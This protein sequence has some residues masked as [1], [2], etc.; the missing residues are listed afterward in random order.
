MSY[1]FTLTY[2]A[3]WD[4]LESDSTFTDA[5]KPGNRIKITENDKIKPGMQHG[6]LPQVY[7]GATTGDGGGQS[8]KS[9]VIT[10]SYP[11][12]ISSGDQNATVSLDLE[13][14]VMSILTKGL[15]TLA[16][17]SGV[18]KVEIIQSNTQYVQQEIVR[19]LIKGYTSV[20]TLQ[21]TYNVS[22]T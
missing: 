15:S 6:D 1:P 2:D 16:A 11:I 20:V 22:R 17:V 7:I 8:N 14:L 9:G 12:I 4:L 19:L 13:W 10:K 3:I 18:Q 21:I 5:V